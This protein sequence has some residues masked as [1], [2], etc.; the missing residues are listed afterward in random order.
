MSVLVIKNLPEAVHE[1][2]KQRATRNHRS[3]NKEAIA[4]LEAAVIEPKPAEMT[5]AE[6][7]AALAD[8]GERLQARG[9]DFDAWA[10]NSRDVWR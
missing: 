2:L 3:L 1:R 6:K 7:F 8:A 9:V 5:I 10:A 4:V